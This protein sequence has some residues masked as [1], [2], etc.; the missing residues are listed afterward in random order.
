MS[1]VSGR[2]SESIYD[3]R[4]ELLVSTITTAMDLEKTNEHRAYEQKRRLCILPLG[5][6]GDLGKSERFWRSIHGCARP[7]VTRIS[8][9][10]LI[11]PT[12]ANPTAMHM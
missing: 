12:T 8:L 11:T 1:K 6:I 9:S 4:E 3:I 10:H 7:R 5:G 2:S